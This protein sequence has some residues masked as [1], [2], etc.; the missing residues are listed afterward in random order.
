MSQR[1]DGFT[2][3][4]GDAGIERVHIE[5]RLDVD[6]ATALMERTLKG[7]LQV[8]G[9]VCAS[10]LIAIGTV[11]AL[12]RQGVSIPNEVS[13]IGYDDI[14]YCRYIHPSLSTVSQNAIRSARLLLSKVISGECSNQDSELLSTD[15]IIRET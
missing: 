10:D 2:K 14:E 15:L 11:N 12:I 5:C 13:V 1:F 9:I 3:A 7:G 8:D 4:T 6:A